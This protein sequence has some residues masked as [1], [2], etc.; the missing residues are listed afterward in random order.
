MFKNKRLLI[1]FLLTLLVAAFI[2]SY[3]IDRSDIL[4]DRSDERVEF[5]PRVIGKGMDLPEYPIENKSFYKDNP[6]VIQLSNGTTIMRGYIHKIGYNI[7]EE[8]NFH[9]LLWF[10]G[11]GS[12]SPI[13]YRLHPNDMMRSIEIPKYP[14]LDPIEVISSMEN[15][16]RVMHSSRVIGEAAND[17][18]NVSSLDAGRAIGIMMKKRTDWISN[19][20]SS[21]KTDTESD[22][23]F[24][25]NDLRM[26]REEMDSI[27]INPTGERM[28]EATLEKVIFFRKDST[29]PFLLVEMELNISG[30]NTRQVF[31]IDDENLGR[32]KII[33]NKFVYAS[34]IQEIS[35]QNENEPSINLTEVYTQNDCLPKFL[36]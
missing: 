32:I 13:V 22:Q 25:S 24:E 21:Q 18:K 30:K 28:V 15:G 5:F 11:R 34:M 14:Q 12:D 2:T 4:N 36:N 9:L 17:Y 29:T 16:E 7:S 26:L 6:R 1:G 8:G 23:Q 27:H 33:Q 19:Q 20:A 10:S 3:L 31:S 35:P